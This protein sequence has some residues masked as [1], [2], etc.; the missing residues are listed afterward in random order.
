MR[1]YRFASHG[2]VAGAVRDRPALQGAFVRTPL[3]RRAI[4]R[5]HKGRVCPNAIC[6]SAFKLERGDF[7]FFPRLLSP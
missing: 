6:A 4:E 2:Y 1:T 7:E 3:S 5:G